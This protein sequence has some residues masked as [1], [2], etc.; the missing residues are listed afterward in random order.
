MHTQ[1]FYL[2]KSLLL[3]SLLMAANLVHGQFNIA[4]LPAGGIYLKPQLWNVS[5]SNTSA[6][7]VQ[8]MLRLDMKDI[9]TGQT[10][11]SAQSAAFRVTPGVRKIQAT[12]IEPIVYTYGPGVT[13]DRN[14]NG[15]LPIGKYRVCYQLMWSYGEHQ[16][17]ATDDCDDI[18]VEPLSPPLLT[19]PENDSVVSRANPDFTWTPPAPLSMFGELKYDVQISPLLDGQSITDAIQQNLPLQQ[20]TG[21]RQPFLTYPLQGPQLESGRRYVWQ[22]VV[23]DGAQ[24]ACKSEI[25]TFRTADK[26]LVNEDH[27]L[28]YLVLDKKTTGRET[29][30]SDTLHL[31]YTA[32]AARRAA[33]LLRTEAGVTL[34]KIMVS[35]REGDNYLHIPL[36]GKFQSRQT[37]TAALEE[38]DGT[39]SGVSFTIK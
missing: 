30:G 1:N 12:A 38:P 8:A 13:I 31:K 9:Q 2:G 17:A 35:L 14:P 25:W 20:A 27:N 34:T 3:A 37:Y 39:M 33:L 6:A 26:P 11:L 29:V 24:Y 16:E 10:V 18:L 22:V 23:R 28:V 21:L 19:L 5:V 15:T 7:T 4:I 36:R 32:L